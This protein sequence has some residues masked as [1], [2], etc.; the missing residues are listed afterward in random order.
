MYMYCTGAVN[1]RTRLAAPSC[2]MY[3]LSTTT[4]GSSK[5]MK[6]FESERE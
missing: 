6:P 3:G 2:R 4:S 1:Q 5:E